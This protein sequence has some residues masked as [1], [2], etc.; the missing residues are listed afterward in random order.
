MS[1]ERRI[2]TAQPSGL[3]TAAV[4]IEG[5]ELNR[6]FKLLLI[7][8]VRVFNRIAYARLEY[9]DGS[10]A[11]QDFKL[12]N[13]D[14]FKPGKAIE[15]LSGYHSENESIFKGVIISHSV[16]VKGGKGSHLVIEAYDKAVKLAAARKSAY[17]YNVKDSEIIEQLAGDAGLEKDVEGTEVTHEETALYHSSPWDFIVMRAEANGQLV[18]THDNKLVVKKPDTSGEPV[19]Q[20]EFGATLHEFEAEIDAQTQFAAVKSKAWNY[21]DQEVLESE[22]EDAAVTGGG[23]IT[24]E[25]LAGVL[26]I[27]ELPLRHTGKFTEG[28]LKSWTTSQITRNKLSRIR[29]RARFQGFAGVK[30]GD[31]IE[32]KGVGNRFNG[33]A[34]VTGVRHQ[35]STAT[36]TTDVQFGFSRDWFSRLPDITAPK[37]AGLL[38]GVNGLQIGVVTKLEADPQGEDRIQVKMPMID[39]DAEGMWARVSTLDAGKERGSFFRPEIGDEVLLGFLNDDPRHPVVLG[40]M[41]SKKLPAPLP[42]ADDNHI[43]GFVTRS[44][45]KLLFDDDKK[46]FTVVTP[47]EQTVVIDDDAGKVTIKDKNSNSMIMSDSGIAIESGKDITIK[48]TGD[49]K[50]E[51][52]NIEAKASAQLKAEGSAGAEVKSGGNTVVKGSM[53]QI[54]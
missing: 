38:P 23:D 43:K 50:M 20:L 28:E 17:Y 12:S 44:K 48:A 52:V 2:P 8:I 3:N 6:E 41:N 30:P 9:H 22:G 34:F 16:R 27:E 33:K 5:Q 46:I 40:M 15:I 24:S 10:A 53:V 18:L 13:K 26:G 25:D 29:G 32:L 42:A 7:E 54:N 45:I 36:W 37:A 19:L 47:G 35:I 14:E 39:N 11:D 21:T 51:A 31:M 4:L 49:I 1:N